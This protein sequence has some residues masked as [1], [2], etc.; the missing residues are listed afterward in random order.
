MDKSEI[1][2]KNTVVHILDAG[3]GIAVY[4]DAEPEYGSDFAD[5]LR[6]HICRVYQSDDI[7]SCRFLEDS[8]VP[9]LL[10]EVME[11]K[12][13]FLSMSRELCGMLYEIMK[14]NADIPSADVAVVYFEV[15]AVPNLAVLK[16]N[17]KSGYTHATETREN[18]NVNNIIKYH[19]ILPAGSQKLSEAAVINL[20]DLQIRLLEK[21]Y[22]INGVK[23]NYFSKHFLECSTE[24]SQKA[25][26]AVVEKAVQSVQKEF[27]NESEQF[28]EH[29]KAKSIIHNEIA[30]QGSISIPEVAA[31]VFE[32]N[33]AMHEKFREKIEKYN[34][35]EQSVIEP[36]NE[37]T[38]KKFSK[39]YLTTDTGIEIKIPMEQYNSTDNI[40]FMTNEDGTISMLIK[41]IGHIMSK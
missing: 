3:L 36:K 29:M 24:I 38:T 10:R 18:K 23:E 33:E 34:I 26:L 7:K 21:K 41:N 6:E 40:E 28:E 15:N 5:F 27:L 12:K 8:K 16:M 2:I 1:Q 20:S 37:A 25:K 11:E 17:Y 39:Q 35:P 14:E 9:A 19:S 32:N 30:E 13:D 31:K 4:S 22:E